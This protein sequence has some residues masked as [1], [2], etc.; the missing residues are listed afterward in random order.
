VFTSRATT[1]TG[2]SR[3]R[4]TVRTLGRLSGNT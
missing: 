2:T 3:M 4:M 1:S